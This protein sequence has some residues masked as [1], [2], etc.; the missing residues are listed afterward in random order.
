MCHRQTIGECPY[1]NKD[2]DNNVEFSCAGCPHIRKANKIHLI[3]QIGLIIAVIIFVITT[4]VF[5]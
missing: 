3:S 1:Y 2:K 5:L 4:Y